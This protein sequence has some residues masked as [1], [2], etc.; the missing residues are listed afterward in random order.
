MPVTFVAASSLTARRQ[1][2]RR[3]LRQSPRLARLQR[4]RAVRSMRPVFSRGRA[5]VLMV[6]SSSQIDA[7][8]TASAD[9]DVARYRI[10]CGTTAARALLTTVGASPDHDTGLRPRFS[11]GSVRPGQAFAAGAA[12]LATKPA[13]PCTRPQADHRQR[14]GARQQRAPDRSG[15]GPFVRSGVA[16]G[17]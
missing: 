1:V 13:K 12:L 9:P 6:V 10:Y 8:W 5:R 16:S 15:R 3:A 7:S 17:D 11:V 2:A 14:A 4:R